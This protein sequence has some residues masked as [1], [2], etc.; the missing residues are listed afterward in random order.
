MMRNVSRPVWRKEIGDVLLCSNAPI[1]YPTSDGAQK[2]AKASGPGPFSSLPQFPLGALPH[3]AEQTLDGVGCS[4]VAMQRLRKVVKGERLFFFLSQTPH[5]LWIELTIFGFE[6]SQL[7][8]RS[9]FAGLS[10][11]A[12]QFGLDVMAN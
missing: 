7:R 3:I 12:Q 10:P 11:D 8:Q 1:S 6:G 4:D 2:K 9:L 5:C